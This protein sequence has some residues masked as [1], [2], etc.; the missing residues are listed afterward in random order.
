[1]SLNYFNLSTPQNEN[2]LVNQRSSIKL[3]NSLYEF[4]EEA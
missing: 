1:M 4:I 2:M 3:Q